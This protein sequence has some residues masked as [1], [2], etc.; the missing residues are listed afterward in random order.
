M[1]ATEAD[2]EQ[3]A[4]LLEFLQDDRTGRELK[5]LILE[6][7]VSKLADVAEHE[8]KSYIQQ[9]GVAMLPRYA[10]ANYT[11]VKSTSADSPTRPSLAADVA[12]VTIKN[13]ELRAAK[14]S[15]G[16]E[17]SARENGTYRGLR[18]WETDL[19]LHDDLKP[20]RVVISM[21]GEAGNLEVSRFLQSL[22]QICPNLQLCVLLGMAA[23]VQSQVGLGDVVI[24]TEVLDYVRGRQTPSGLRRRPRSFMPGTVVGRQIGY[25]QPTQGEWMPQLDHAM[26]RLGER[27]FPA[28]LNPDDF[29]PKFKRGV[30]VSGDRLLEDGSLA[31]LGEEV[32]DKTR[33]AEMEGAG[34]AASCDEEGIPW[35]DIRGIA[36]YGR[37]SR[38]KDWQL[39]ATL[40]AGTAL[41]TILERDYRFDDRQRQF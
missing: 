8:R 29:S 22:F 33:A 36:D 15:F 30:I 38:E 37:P 41:R 14:I 23:G 16:I 1:T 5:S 10:R 18:Y 20:L 21:V 4:L 3:L 39:L 19:R 6:D 11:V 28:D 17:E 24:A 34:F 32:H 27:E 31:S 2:P 7:L 12:I 13:P 9:A 26:T 35:L 40:S 25:F